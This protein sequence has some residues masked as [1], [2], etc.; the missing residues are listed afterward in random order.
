MYGIKIEP[1][2]DTCS[3]CRAVFHEDEPNVN[4]AECSGTYH[5]GKCAGVTEKSFKGKSK[6]ARKTWRCPQCRDV[7]P[8]ASNSEGS[9]S[10]LDIKSALASIIEKLDSLPILAQKVEKMEQSLQHI[11]DRFDEF[12]KQVG[13]QESEI[14]ELKK[15]VAELEAKEDMNQVVQTQLQQEVNELEFRNRQ[16]N[17][18]I[19]GIP[20]VAGEDLLA[21]LNSVAEK[22]EVPPLAEA[23]IQTVHRLPTKPDKVPG[24]IVRFTKQAVRDAWLKQ[25]SKLKGSEPPMFIQENLTRHNRELLRAAKE[26]AK[27]KGYRFTWHINGRI[28][29]RKD[30]GTRIIRIKTT[31]DLDRL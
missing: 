25:K 7:G 17:L 19:H 9:D 16:L 28:L 8:R 21:L 5:F 23:D 24:V 15:R 18:E 31:T 6:A 3:S 30:D 2:S 12:E 14:K 11:S 13:R 22:L 4:C 27:D 26:R 20:A 10:E 1:M 29:V